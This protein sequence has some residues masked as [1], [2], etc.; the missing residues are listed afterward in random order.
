[1][2]GIMLPTLASLEVVPAERVDGVL[3][4][5]R[6]ELAALEL[7]L[8]RADED[9]S[10]VEQQVLGGDGP[11]D[12]AT[13]AEQ[14]VHAFLAELESSADRAFAAAIAEA[15][16]EAQARITQARLTSEA[17]LA[18]ARA[19]AGRAVVEAAL[20][21]PP[22]P[23]PATPSAFVADVPGPRPFPPVVAPDP[24]TSVIDASA[25]TTE[26]PIVL[27]PVAAEP[28]VAPTFDAPPVVPEPEVVAPGIDEPAVA[29]APAVEPS[30]AAAPV[31]VVPP[32]VEPPPVPVVESLV[33]DAVPTA[34]DAADD[35]VAATIVAATV[36]A[37]RDLPAEVPET[38]LGPSDDAALGPDIAGQQADEVHEEFWREENEAG[39]SRGLSII[40]IE[41]VLPMI[42]LVIV[43]VVVLAW[44]G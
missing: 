12:V 9:A 39:R 35:A 28:L 43:L 6:L 10:V 2:A 8:Q 31:V 44:I 33:A 34:S 5:M 4:A 30:V 38:E 19:V 29:E 40:P 1:V 25:V 14:Q 24:P 3:D 13:R 41:A 37:I 16:A 22:P 23:A 27:G 42:A 17:M 18:A 36:A 21:P 20:T 15:K 32:F 7:D 11:S 26:V